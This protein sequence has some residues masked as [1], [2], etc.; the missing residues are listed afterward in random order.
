M[1]FSSYFIITW[2]LIRHAR[3]AG[4]RVGPGRGSAAGC[5]VAYCLWITDLDPIRYDLLFERF[6][7]P[8]RV[9]MPD[10]DM[11]FDSRYRDEMIRYAAERYGRDHVAQIV[12]F[13]TIKARAAVRDAARVLGYPYAVG[14][15]V[16]KA[17]PPLVMGRDTPLYACMEPHPKFEDGYK[18]AADLRQ[19]YEEDPDAKAVIDVAKGLE[20]LRRQDGIHAAAVVIT[21]EP[22]TEYLPIQRKPENGVPP[23]EAPVVT[24]YEMH[25]VEE[26]GL[27]KMDFLGLRNLDVISDALELIREHR[28]VEVDIDHV[29]LDDEPTY[30][31]LRRGQSIGVFQLEGGPMRALMRSLAP[32]TF[33]DV[34]A[35][36]A[37]YRPGP[38]AAN[39]HNDYADRKNGR[40]PVEYLH[41][42]A[43]EILA[44]TFGL[45]LTGDTVIVNAMT[46]EPTRLAELDL[47][48]GFWV[49]GVDGE[50]RPVIRQVTHWVCNGEREVLHLRLAN[51]M[52]LSGTPE[53]PVLTERGWVQLGDLH[54]DDHV[55]V[56]RELL[57]PVIEGRMDPAA[58]RI[59]AYLIADGALS[60][61]A[62]VGFVNRD[63]VL[64]DEFRECVATAFSTCRVAESVRPNGVTLLAV[65]NGRGNGGPAS[66][67]LAWLRELGLKSSVGAAGRGGLRSDE[68]FVPAQVFTLGDEQIAWFVASLWDC[69]GYVG[70]RFAH[71]RTI[72][73]RLADDVQ[74]LLMRLGFDATI[75]RAE[76]I[77]PRDGRVMTAYQ[78]T[79]FDGA[80]FAALIAPHLASRAKREAVFAAEHSGGTVARPLVMSAVREAWTGSVRELAATTGLSRGQFA[81]RFADMRMK[82]SSAA[83]LADTL[84][85]DDV[86]R[87]LRLA[88]VP[89]AGLE[90]AGRELVYDITVDEV[91][92]F[93]ANGIVT[94][95]C[96]YQEQVMRVAQKFAGYSLAEADSLRKSM[97]KKKRELMVIER[98][99]FVAGCESQGYGQELGE[100]WFAIIEQ[101]ADYAFNRSHSFGYGYVS[102]QT[103]YLKANYP[104][105]YLAALLTSVKTNLEKAAVYLAECRSM[106]ITVEVP[107]VNRS[108]SDF[109]PEA[110]P[111][112]DGGEKLSIVFGLSAVRNVGTGL[113]ELIVRERDENGPFEDFYDFCERVDPRS[114]EQ[115]DAGVADQGRRLRQ[116]GAP[117]QGPADG[118]RADRGLHPGPAAGAGHGRDEPVRRGRG[119]RRGLR[120]AGRHPGGGVRQAGA[121]QLREGDAR[122]LRLGP[123]AHGG[124][125]RPQAPVRRLA[126]RPG[127]DGRRHHAQLRRGHHE[128]PAEVDPQGRPHGRVPAGGPAD[129]GRGH[130]VPQD[131]GRARPQA[132]GRPGRGGQGPGRRAG[133][134]AQAHRHGHRAVR[135]DER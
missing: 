29:P 74:R 67:L 96:V 114:A 15:K 130:G 4:I 53:H 20:G 87:H 5:A 21:K 118:L 92:N 103:A 80:R 43:E 39:M 25:G 58:L 116:R 119:R 101:F 38:M 45:C 117:P 41:P 121:A 78:V 99:K 85:L 34:A 79:V 106:D 24:Q 65:G 108:A 17:M 124:G 52:E 132:R 107:D 60:T 26:L 70:A 63:P 127:G 56:P 33:E 6:L 82:A 22:L 61:K 2:D 133:R 31:M 120:R 97:G 135:A 10:I 104:A 94:H 72:S 100:T 46:G 11:D 123:P 112:A 36:V 129:L 14:D 42:D 27:L 3:E 91:H 111:T 69:D 16:A 113:V 48:E 76:Y 9:S 1:G 30:E 125:G 13:S 49:Q 105:E 115:E 47:S 90:S 75:Y 128:P 12:T 40:K 37:L 35:L 28:G 126:G 102:Y 109:T 54:A 66:P 59:L 73:K 84:D 8:S 50:N 62:S 88:W 134:P 131:H 89:V 32:T 110:E 83:V 71:Y 81:P 93:V 23:E 18:M 68:K 44:E 77:R 57:G 86:D 64:L 19:M 98:D 122:P 51:G 95:N 7:N 55:A